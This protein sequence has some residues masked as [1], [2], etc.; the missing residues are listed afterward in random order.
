MKT[1]AIL[2]GILAGLGCSP[3]APRQ[4]PPTPPPVTTPPPRAPS[5]LEALLDYV[6][7]DAVAVVAID[8]EQAR[9]SPALTRAVE[10]LL[11][12]LGHSEL[13][14]GALVIALVPAQPGEPAGSLVVVAAPGEPRL[15]GPAALIARATAAHAG[16]SIAEAGALR[17]PL[18]AARGGTAGFAAVLVTEPLRTEARAVLPD[19]ATATW[20]T[21]SLDVASGILVHVIG[22]FPDLTTAVRVAAAVDLGKSFALGELRS[23]HPVAARAIDKMFARPVGPTLRLTATLDEP[24]AMALLGLLR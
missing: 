17:E 3:E 19:L 1:R 15:V 8:L 4:S 11:A 13:V 12:Q 9:R 23:T 21:A 22:A 20:F 5:D 10:L 7:P 14:A 18:A 2:V 16:H 24:E 6:P